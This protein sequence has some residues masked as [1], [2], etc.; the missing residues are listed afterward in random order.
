M[1]R[2]DLAA[3]GI[4]GT[5][6]SFGGRAASDLARRLEIMGREGDLRGAQSVL[7]ELEVEMER[8]A[9]FFSPGGNDEF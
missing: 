2:L 9:A 8:F 1:W 3:H 7:E 6:S 4:T 5:L